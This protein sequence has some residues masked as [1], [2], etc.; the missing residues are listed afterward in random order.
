MG[1]R[2]RKDKH[3]PQRVYVHHGS[4]RYAPKHGRPVRLAAI[5]DYSGMLR[6]LA[7]ILGESP[8][9][10]TMS[11]LFDR[12]ELEV[13]PSKSPS[14]QS[15]QKRQ[16]VNLRKAFGH[17][18]P[19]HLM[20]PHAVQYRSKR[21]QKA[22]TAANREMELLS[23]V[24][25]V[26]VEWG[27]LQAN[28]L[29]GMRKLRRPPRQR[30]VTN[31]E[32]LQVWGLASPMVQCVMDIA[33]LT[34]L[35]RGDIFALQRKHMTDDG[36]I[37]RPSKTS[38]TSGATLLFE[39]SPGLRTVIEKALLISPQVRQFVVCNGKGRPFTKNGF[40]S[41][42]SR[43]MR[44]ACNDGMER[45]QFKDLRRKSATDETDLKTAQERLGHTKPEITA[46]VYR[47]KP[48]R[49]KPLR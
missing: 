3:L 16:L 28:P 18:Q 19:R 10:E 42:W 1:R 24:C 49:V 22:P 8:K 47:V 46:R 45:W 36:L 4:Y 6:A 35:R 15:D 9:I 11:D 38:S 21:A 5:D 17:M 26:G 39:W 29:R 40:D 13:I 14:T 32:Y 43:L 12:Y 20:Q 33:L 25:T 31:D 23:H 2:R 34:G 37:V 30:Y 7:D 48:N 27:A 41:V 44:K